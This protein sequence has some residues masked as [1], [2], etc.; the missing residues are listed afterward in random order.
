MS[1]L[2]QEKEEAGKCNK[3]T[4]STL[5][6]KQGRDDVLC[7]WRKDPSRAIEWAA[8]VV[9]EAEGFQTDFI[10]SISSHEISTALRQVNALCGQPKEEEEEEAGATEAFVSPAKADGQSHSSAA[11]S[12]DTQGDATQ[13]CRHA[14]RRRPR[15][16]DDED[17]DDEDE[18][19]SLRPFSPLSTSPCTS[20]TSSCRRRH[21]GDAP[22]KDDGDDDN[23]EIDKDYEGF[24]AVQFALMHF[25]EDV[26]FS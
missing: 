8:H 5:G 15:H 21:D 12:C 6:K 19:A 16:D 1:R 11:K 14:Y 3:K 17:D 20:S 13:H 23:D 9:D 24:L 7:A 25:S 4:G 18:D 26:E 10:G 22:A 2:P